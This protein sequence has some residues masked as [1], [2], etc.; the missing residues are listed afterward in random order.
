MNEVMPVVRLHLFCGKM[1]AGKSTLATQIAQHEGA[2]LIG[3]D[4]MLELLY[5]GEILLLADFIKFSAR[6]RS[7][8]APHIV[9]LLKH[10]TSVVLDFAGNTPKQRAWFRELIQQPGTAHILHFLDVSDLECKAQLKRRSA[11]LPAGARFTS[12]AEFDAVTR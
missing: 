12:E 1:A 3:E 2:L 6:L 11:A 8:V 7:A 10:G 5:P 9:W 4:A